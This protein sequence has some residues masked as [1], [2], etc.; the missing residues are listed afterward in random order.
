MVSSLCLHKIPSDGDHRIY[1][2][3]VLSADSL[4]PLTIV[5]QY[6]Q[7]GLDLIANI[8]DIPTG[9]DIFKISL[10]VR[11]RIRILLFSSR[12][13]ERFHGFGYGG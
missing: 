9:V 2:T 7:M 13:F 10:I 1:I 8:M 4:T 5:L 12:E 3:T 11:D 6:T